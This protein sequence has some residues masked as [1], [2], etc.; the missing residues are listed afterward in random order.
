[1]FHLNNYLFVVVLRA[2][3]S[4]DDISYLV[5]ALRGDTVIMIKFIVEY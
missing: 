4:V 1:V 5:T 3:A 2:F